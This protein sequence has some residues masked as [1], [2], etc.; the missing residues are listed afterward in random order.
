MQW[1]VSGVRC[2]VSGVRCQVSNVTLLFFFKWLSYLVEGVLS[3]GLTPSSLF[4]VSPPVTCHLSHVTFIFIYII[5]IFFDKV[6]KLVG[7]GSYS[8]GSD[9][10]SKSASALGSPTSAI[11]CSVEKCPLFSVLPRMCNFLYNQYWLHSQ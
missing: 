6:V 2:Q 7:G 10:D 4:H 8:G 11:V 3:P 5:I 9:S 1:W